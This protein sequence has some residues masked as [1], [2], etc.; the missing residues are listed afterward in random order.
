MLGRGAWLG[1]V[2]SIFGSFRKNTSLSQ[3]HDR[4]QEGSP[5][6]NSSGAAPAQQQQG[7]PSPNSNR[8]T[9]APRAPVQPS[10]NNGRA[11]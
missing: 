8:A 6:P 9:L 4:Q 7:S 3:T 10:P 1:G 11:A 2:K 5:S